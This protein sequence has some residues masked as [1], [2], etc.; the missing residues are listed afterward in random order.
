MLEVSN[1][2]DKASHCKETSHLNVIDTLNLANLSAVES[3]MDKAIL[4]VKV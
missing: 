3:I 4:L 2:V 1:N